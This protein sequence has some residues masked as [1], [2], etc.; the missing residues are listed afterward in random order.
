MKKNFILWTFLF[1]AAIPVMASPA[2]NY[3]PKALESAQLNNEK[4]VLH[5]LAAWCPTCR[6]QIKTLQ[7]MDPKILS[8]VHFFNVDF[9]KEEALKAKLKIETQSTFV[10]F[11]G[12][13]E[14]GRVTGITRAKDI[15][16]FLKKNLGVSK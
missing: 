1:W 14:E 15:E 11:I 6:I 3:T 8:G 4:I 12:K 16:D 10:A 7:G 5:F 13:S 2:E 9:D